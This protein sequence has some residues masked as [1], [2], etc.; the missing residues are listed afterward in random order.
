MKEWR[1]DDRE[2]GEHR[3]GRRGPSPIYQGDTD[4]LGTDCGRRERER[5]KFGFSQLLERSLFFGI[6]ISE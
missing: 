5:C 3:E 6:V 4:R 2:K 1:M